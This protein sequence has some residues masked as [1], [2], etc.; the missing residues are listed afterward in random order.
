MI[1][2]TCGT[3]IMAKDNFVRFECPDCGKTE[4]AR[5]KMCKEL[6]NKYICKECEFTGP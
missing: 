4:I 2:S 3:H 5:C 6:C 1:C